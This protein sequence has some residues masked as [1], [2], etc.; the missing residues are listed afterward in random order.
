MS[1][2]EDYLSRDRDGFMHKITDLMEDDVLVV[3][4]GAIPRLKIPVKYVGHNPEKHDNVAGTGLHWKQDETLAVDHE[5]AE[6]LLMYPDV[7]VYDPDFVDT[8]T[9]APDGSAVLE[10]RATAEEVQALLEGRAE[11]RIVPVG[12][13]QETSEEAPVVAPPVEGEQA[14]VAN[15]KDVGAGDSKPEGEGGQ[16]ANNG[17]SEVIDPVD[18]ILA[19]DKAG[20]VDFAQEKFGVK[21]DK[22]KSLD[23]LR[24][25]VVELLHSKDKPPVEG[26]QAQ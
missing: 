25:Q 3:A 14:G 18:S 16:E 13:A 8:Y 21:L 20:L 22:R 24:D 17:A 10:Y 4:P 11:L 23:D 1:K 7:W 9:V 2:P 26:E 12:I 5:A 15:A 6:K 19:L